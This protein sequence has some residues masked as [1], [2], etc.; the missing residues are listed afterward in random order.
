MIGG[1]GWESNPPRPATQPATGFEDQE[2]HRDL[3]TPNGKDN[4]RGIGL[5]AGLSGVIK[6]VIVFVQALKIN[7]GLFHLASLH[8]SGSRWISHESKRRRL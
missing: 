6:V 5:Q 1:S 4:R 3:T 2:A 8:F 7:R